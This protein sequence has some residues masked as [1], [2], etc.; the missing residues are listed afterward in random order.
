MDILGYLVQGKA[1]KEIST[2]LNLQLST[3]STHK[4]RIFRKLNVTNIVELIALTKEYPL[5]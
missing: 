3:I 2:L 4:F 1:T 5:Y